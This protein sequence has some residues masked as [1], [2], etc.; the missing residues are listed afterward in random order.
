MP[1]ETWGLA[2]LDDSRVLKGPEVTLCARPA[3]E[4]K[5]PAAASPTGDYVAV[6]LADRGLYLVPATG[7]E[8]RLL[9]RGPVECAFWHDV[10]PWAPDGKSLVYVVKGNLYHQP[11]SGQ[12]RQLTTT[13]DAQT[14]AVSPDG[15]QVAYG[16]FSAKQQDLGL[17]VVPTAGGEPKRLVDATGD[18]FS[19]GNPHWSPDGQWIAFL[20][21]WEGGALGVVNVASGESRTGLE[22]A[23]EPLSWLPDSTG[24][25]FPKWVYEEG[26]DGLWRYDVAGGKPVQIAAKGTDA[27]CAP[28]PDGTRL[29]L[30]TTAAGP[31]GKPGQTRVELLSWPLGDKPSVLLEG[32]ADT[33]EARWS[34]EGKQIAILMRTGTVPGGKGNVYYGPPAPGQLRLAGHGTNLVGWVK[35]LTP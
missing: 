2:Y 10:S 16:R 27:I 18:V 28:S 8:P 21:A 20:Q 7:A 1:Q 9:H 29:L 22:A 35:T 3:L 34:P 30:T 12:P 5:H 32:K 19:A 13:G 23:W 26:G 33:P 24:V 11:L 14:P 17:W 15:Q 31:D 6:V 25:I 4:E